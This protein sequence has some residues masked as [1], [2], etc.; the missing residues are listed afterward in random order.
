M[1]GGR[2]EEGRRFVRARMRWDPFAET[3]PPKK[4]VD[5]NCYLN[6]V[7]LGRCR[8]GAGIL[9]Y[10]AGGFRLLCLGVRGVGLEQRAVREDAGF[11][12]LF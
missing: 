7:K 10:G 9:G 4:R 3:A 1:A 2:R 12:G 5:F 11:E 6:L 8:G